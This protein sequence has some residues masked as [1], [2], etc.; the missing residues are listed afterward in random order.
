MSLGID[1]VRALRGRGTTILPFHERWIRRACAPG[2]EVAAL[3]APRGSA[4]SWCFGQLAALALRPSSPTWESGIETLMVSGS[5]EQSRIMLS[6]VRQALEDVEDDYRWLDSGQR[7]QVTHKRTGTKLRVLSSSGKRALGLSQFSTIYADEPASYEA[8]GGALMWDALRQSL[9]KRA[10]QRLLLIGTRAPAEPGSWWPELLDAG[11]GAG[12]HVEVLAA[13]PDDPWDK[14]T[15]A[16]KCNPLLRVSESLRKT[17]LRERD[18]ARKSP[19][20]RRSYEAFR[21][22]RMIDV[23][24]EVLVELEAWRR[25]EAREVPP[26]EGRPIVGLDVGSERS[27]SGAWA[28]W[29]NGRSEAYALCPGIPDLDARERQ[30]GIPRGLYRRLHQDG[31]LLVD[32]D[33]R[34]SRPAVLIDHL[35]GLG[36]RPRAIL[37]DRF[38]LGALQDA[39]AGRCPVIPRTTRWSEATEDIA[40]FRRLVA[41]GPL[42]IV[43]EGRALATLALSQASVVSDDQGSVRI[44]KKR[45]GRSR[46]DVAVCAVLAAG[47]LV[48]L[49]GREQHRYRWRYRGAA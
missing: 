9:G 49:L 18:E 12:R 46:D 15:T 37:C 5:L 42:S 17:V 8:R 26:R 6:F 23:S 40:S 25:V 19:T 14:W 1:I 21:L 48:R 3:S 47:A 41:D 39:V 30:D 11:S 38:M 32:E 34:V 36:I 20:M 28:L 10:G 7:L 35:F 31:V 4:K 22:N 27:W 2:I 13:P 24:V 43:P 33:L 16:V 45:H 29:P 44:Q